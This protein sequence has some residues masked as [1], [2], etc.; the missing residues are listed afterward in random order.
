MPTADQR[1]VN[2]Q[3]RWIMLYLNVVIMT[4]MS[5]YTNPVGTLLLYHYIVQAKS[6]YTGPGPSL[7]V[8]ITSYSHVNSP[9]SK[10][11]HY[12]LF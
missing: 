9:G 7:V 11:T 5:R 8:L 6:E 12:S 2:P 1:V 10:L 3:E 4:A